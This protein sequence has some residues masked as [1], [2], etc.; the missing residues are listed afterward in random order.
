MLEGGAAGGCCGTSG[1]RACPRSA[2]RAGDWSRWRRRGSRRSSSGDFNAPSHQDWTPRTV[3]QRPQI[4][5]P[6]RWP[7]QRLLAEHG[8]RRHVPR[9][10]SRTFWRPLGSTWPVGRPRSDTSWNPAA[11]APH[12]RIDQIWV[13]GPAPRRSQRDRRASAAG[14]TSTIEVHPWGSDHR[15]VVSTVDVD[16]RHAAGHGVPRPAAG[17]AGAGSHGDLP[18]AGGAGEKVVIVPVG[19]RPRDRRASTQAGTPAADD[20]DGSVVRSR[21]RLASGGY[22]AVLVDGA[23][24]RA[25]PDAVLAPRCR[26]NAPSVHSASWS[27][28][29]GEPIAI[30][31]HGAP[32]QPVRLDRDLRAGRR[33]ARSPIT[34]PTCTRGAARRGC[35]HVRWRYR[36]AVAAADRGD[37]PRIC[38]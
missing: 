1:R 8:V 25:L 18:R 4:R 14:R 20:V 22:D 31:W 21:P 15:A 36:E 23:R 17:R 6:V 32:A 13:A 3:G 7:V 9:R 37:T 5:F 28:D 2:L 30:S 10:A 33:S 29:V 11:D 12:D 24:R 19:R 34:R 38:W 16:A 27:Y 26:A 35:G